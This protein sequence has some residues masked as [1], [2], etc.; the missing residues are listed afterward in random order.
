MMTQ[1]NE[2]SMGLNE[3]SELISVISH[4]DKHYIVSYRQHRSYSSYNH[5]IEVIFKVWFRVNLFADSASFTDIDHLILGLDKYLPREWKWGL[6]L[7]I[8]T[9]MTEIYM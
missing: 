6:E 7:I 5:I 9:H 3:F 8:D 1:F 4:T 2:V